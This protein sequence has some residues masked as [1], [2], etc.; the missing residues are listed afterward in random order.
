MTQDLIVEADGGVMALA[1]IIPHVRWPRLFFAL[2]PRQSG[3]MR[4]HFATRC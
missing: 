1:N 3:L 2:F 4:C